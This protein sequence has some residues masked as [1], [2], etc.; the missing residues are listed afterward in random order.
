[1]IKLP[2]TTNRIGDY[3]TDAE[4][5]HNES[6]YECFCGNPLLVSSAERIYCA[7]CQRYWERSEIDGYSGRQ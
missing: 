1:M 7:K 2:D 5:L 4:D 6:G 3:P